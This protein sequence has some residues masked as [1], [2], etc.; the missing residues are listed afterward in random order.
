MAVKDSISVDLT[1]SYQNLVTLAG[2]TAGKIPIGT[3]TANKVLLSV[4]T[5]AADI[6]WGES[7]PAIAGHPVAAGDSYA[8][9]GMDL[10]RNC[11]VKNTVV[12]DTSTLIITA[13]QVYE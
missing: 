6:A 3:A 5:K 10:I 8:V 4:L 1:G 7:A 2:G 11:W 13:F 12:A 9:E